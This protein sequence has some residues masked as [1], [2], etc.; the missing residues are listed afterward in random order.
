MENEKN[1]KPEIYYRD[2]Y[3]RHTV[4]QCRRTEK[5]LKEKDIAKSPEAEK[6]SKEDVER[7]K[8]M[9]EYFTLHM[10]IG[11]RYLNKKETIRK[12]MDADRAKDEL[13]ESAQAPEGIRCLSCRN[14]MKPNFKEL[15]TEYEKP[16]RV[17]FMYDC[18]NN[19]LPRRA[20]FD[21]GEEWRAK[22]NLCPNCNTKL[23]EKVIKEEN[24]LATN[25]LCPKCGYADTEE[26][27]FTHKEEPF[28]DKFA[29]DRDRFCLTDEEGKKYSDE[30]WQLE[31]MA[32][33]GKE[34]E[35][36]EKALAEKLKANPKGF[37]L[38]GAGYTCF[39]C[40]DS[41]PEGD[42]WYDEWGIKCL[43]CQKAIDEGEIPAS[44]AK[45]K[46]SW[47]SMFDI[48]YNFEVKSPT[49]RKWIRQ[50]LL[51]PRNIS[52]YGNGI[53]AQIFL[54]EENKD[55]LPPK[56]LIESKL[57]YEIKDGKK[58]YHSEKWYRFGDPH[59]LL[60]DYKI[61]DYLRAV[62]EEPPKADVGK[63]E[64]ENKIS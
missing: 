18:P 56:K 55:F 1:L 12:W 53:H 36:K 28:D 34:F 8:H 63:K 6:F 30:K 16:D 15:W 62:K 35:E 45:E 51:K 50:G 64:G 10:E 58:M 14:V 44:L 41:T 39:I 43:V 25:Y 19:C 40:G 38:E 22:Q 46:D 57:V 7:V 52:R 3:D 21:N 29:A 42:N 48:E 17:L 59:K 27:D 9:V 4:E 13:Y 49:L 60:K 2:L 24:K 33:L 26:M 20:F 47:Y 61:M 54:I 11:E 31:Q 32:R 5:L 23:D 37:H